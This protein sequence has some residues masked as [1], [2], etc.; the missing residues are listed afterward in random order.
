MV[1][2]SLGCKIFD[3]IHSTKVV[4]MSFWALL[5]WGTL[6]AAILAQARVHGL[7]PCHEVRVSSSKRSHVPWVAWVGVKVYLWV[8]RHACM[9]ACDLGKAGYGAC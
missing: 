7:V 8:L 2:L 6:G 4:H 3:H 9:H 1:S 5:H